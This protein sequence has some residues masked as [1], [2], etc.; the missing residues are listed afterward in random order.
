MR[1]RYNLPTN[2]ALIAAA[3]K[4]EWIPLAIDTAD[5]RKHRRDSVSTP[6]PTGDATNAS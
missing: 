4:L 6:R 5:D 3:V 1:D 2:E